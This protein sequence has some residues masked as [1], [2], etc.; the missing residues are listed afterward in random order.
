MNKDEMIKALQE[1]YEEFWRKGI[2]II[3]EKNRDPEKPEAVDARDYAIDMLNF[4]YNTAK[5]LRDGLR[6]AEEILNSQGVKIEPSIAET[7]EKLV[8]I[9][10]REEAQRIINVQKFQ[11][12]DNKNPFLA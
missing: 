7:L 5:S 10:S 4:C 9:A 12:K 2:Q 6:H 3:A 1:V 8:V 11:G